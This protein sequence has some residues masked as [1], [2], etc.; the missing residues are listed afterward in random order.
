MAKRKTPKRQIAV[1]TAAALLLGGTALYTVTHQRT[2][3]PLPLTGAITAPVAPI[4]T[5]LARHIE[6]CCEIN[7]IDPA[8]V[9]A[10][11]ERE[12]D[13]QPDVVNPFSGCVG[14]MQLHPSTLKWLERETGCVY[15]PYDPY[16]NTAGGIYLLGWL[17]QR[18]DQH[19]PS[20]LLAYAEGVGGADAMLASG[21]DPESTWQYRTVIERMVKYEQQIHG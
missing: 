21:I 17:M 13:F 15:N 1:V 7:G 12:S 2:G 3:D 4:S 14:L 10:I 19:V 18:Y 6:S 11:I 5:R 20:A 9:F 16:Q 8:I